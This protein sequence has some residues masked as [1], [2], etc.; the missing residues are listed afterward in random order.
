MI[1][2]K[3]QQNDCALVEKIVDR[4]EILYDSVM[5]PFDRKTVMMD[6]VACHLN[7]TPLDLEKLLK[8]ED[9]SFAHDVFG[10]S[11]HMNRETGKIERNF[12][13]RCYKGD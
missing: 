10:I 2:W 1:D 12:L 13:P 5:R 7:G 11:G 3:I 6:I 9:F 4:A 8:A